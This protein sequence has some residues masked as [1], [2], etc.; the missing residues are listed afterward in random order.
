VLHH[1]ERYDGNGYPH[2]L[3][4]SQIPLVSR[5]IAVADSYS[6]MVSDRPYGP[7]LPTVIAEAELEFRKGSQFDPEVVE[8]FLELLERSDERYRL[9]RKAD[10]R[11]EVQDVKFLRELPVEP[12]GEA[13]AEAV[14]VLREKRGRKAGEDGISAREARQKARE[15]TVGQEASKVQDASKRARTRV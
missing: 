11:M 5:I 6:A 2:G 9:G 3:A 1:H 8:Y 4:G 7:P 14:P 15:R 13:A 10:F 12:E